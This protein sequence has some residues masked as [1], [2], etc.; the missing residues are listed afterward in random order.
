MPMFQQKQI[1]QLIA[2]LSVRAKKEHAGAL[3]Q[4]VFELLDTDYLPP[5]HTEEFSVDVIA[6]ECLIY[7]FNVL[8]IKVFS[9]C[10][11]VTLQ[12]TKKCL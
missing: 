1:L 5:A 12:V 11:I 3:I 7:A 4:N 2:E 10:S 8:V 6:L 9:G